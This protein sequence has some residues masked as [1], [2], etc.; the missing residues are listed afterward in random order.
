MICITDS[1]T[2]ALEVSRNLLPREELN[3]AQEKSLNMAIGFINLCKKFFDIN[4]N[5][6]D[7]E[8]LQEYQANDG[9][10]RELF[11]AKKHDK[12]YLYATF[13]DTGAKALGVFIDDAELPLIQ[14]MNSK[15]VLNYY[16]ERIY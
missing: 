4:T 9:Q 2:S 13:F 12:H 7:L 8:I 5:L 14:A 6:N 11:L 16:N 10:V 3:Q 15:D 1:L